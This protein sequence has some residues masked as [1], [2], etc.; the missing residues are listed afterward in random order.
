MEIRTFLIRDNIAPN[1]S[2]LLC[3]PACT[4]GQA[5]GDD[6]GQ[7]LW[8][9]SHGQGDG[10]LEVV[11]GSLDPGS[12]VGRVVEVANVDGPHSHTDQGNNLELIF[13]ITYLIDKYCV[14][15]VPVF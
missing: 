7:A 2:I 5:S 15:Q 12:A 4:Q 3:H 1:N 13:F 8:D 6:S 9:G 10:D 14:R 11:D